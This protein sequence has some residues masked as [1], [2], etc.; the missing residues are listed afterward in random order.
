MENYTK[1]IE[2]ANGER[3][4]NIEIGLI[5]VGEIQSFVFNLEELR[6][7]TAASLTIDTLVTA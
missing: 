7:V 2:G 1:P 5:D 4:K 6:I 3:V